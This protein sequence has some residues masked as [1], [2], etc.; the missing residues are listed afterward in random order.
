M[1]ACVRKYTLEFFTLLN[2]KGK[3]ELIEWYMKEGLI[4]LS[5]EC[6]KCNDRHDVTWSATKGFLRNRTS[7][8]EGMFTRVRPLPC[9]INMQHSHDHSLSDE[10][11]KAFLK[12]VVTLYSPLRKDQ[13]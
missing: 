1:A 7:H 9:R 4:A 8:A 6:P 3:K 10:T 2:A 5:Y 11:F 12:S 13:Q